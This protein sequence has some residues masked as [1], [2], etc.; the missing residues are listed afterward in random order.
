MKHKAVQVMSV[1]F[2]AGVFSL[3]ASFDAA[4][5]IKSTLYPTTATFA[6]G[7]ISSDG[8]G[9]YF[10]GVRG[11]SSSRVAGAGTTNGWFW[12][13]A[14][15]TKTPRSLVYDLSVP[16]D[17]TSPH[18]GVITVTNTHGQVYDLST[19]DVGETTFVRAAFHLSIDR[20][21]YVVRFG[22]SPTDGSSALEVTRLS[23]T[24]F[25][26]RTGG[27]GDIARFLRGNGPGE[28]LLGYY[29]MPLDLMLTNQ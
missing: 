13:L 9:P 20:V 1:L 17:A 28:V 12:D 19:L 29:R 3:P 14:G 26:V 7:G 16:A 23:A 22:Q 24:E 18:L 15:R 27:Q 2:V 6:D 11:V 4:Q 5:R 21:T 10:D 8:E 25:H